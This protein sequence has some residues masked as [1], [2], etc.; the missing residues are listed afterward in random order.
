MSR[1]LPA[2]PSLESLRKQAK[3]LQ[4][5]MPQGRLSA[6][7]YALAREY[8][9]P[10]WAKL[11]LHVVTLGLSPDEALKVTVCDSDAQ[12]VTELIESFPELKARIDEPLPNYGFG[13]NALFAAVQRRPDADRIKSLEARSSRRC[14]AAKVYRRFTASKSRMPRAEDIRLSGSMV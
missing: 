6:A 5:A 4:R 7:Q 3:Q 8:G 11:K 9:F 14:A 12:R 2:N 1:E 13:Q 10:T